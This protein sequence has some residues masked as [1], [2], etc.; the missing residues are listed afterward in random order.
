MRDM[1]EL[2]GS[3]KLWLSWQNV[4]IIDDQR[5]GVL[6]LASGGNPAKVSLGKTLNPY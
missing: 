2:V 6:N 3:E 5:V 1:M 4:L